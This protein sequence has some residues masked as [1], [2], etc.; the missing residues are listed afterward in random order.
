MRF[1]EK[2]FVNGVFDLLKIKVLFIKL[3]IKLIFLQV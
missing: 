3:L 2:C 1:K